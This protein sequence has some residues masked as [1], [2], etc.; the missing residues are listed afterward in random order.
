MLKTYILR[1]F[2]L[3]TVTC[4]IAI[5]VVIYA[6]TAS[7]RPRLNLQNTTVVSLMGLDQVVS[8]NGTVTAAQNVDL[9]FERGG[10]VTSL[11]GDVGTPVGK[12]QVIARVESS[13]LD[14]EL[15]QAQAALSGENIKLQNLQSSATSSNEAGSSI[16]TT[17][18]NSRQSLLVQLSTS[19]SAADGALSTYV[20]NLFSNARTNPSFGVTINQNGSVYDITAPASTLLKID[21][22]RQSLTMLMS[23]WSSLAA[24]ATASGNDQDI[25]AAITASQS[26]LQ[27]ATALLTDISAVFTD[28][29]PIDAASQALY[30]GYKTNILLAETAIN[31]NVSALKSSEEAYAQASASASPYSISLEQVAVTTAQSQ[32]A[33]IE[34]QIE[35]GVL[36]SPIDGVITEENIKLGE[37]AGANTPAVSVMSDGLLQID[38]YVFRS[39]H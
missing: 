6:F 39:R 23:S 19:Y 21:A 33:G 15:V 26:A 3:V 34:A 4:V 1:P 36:R 11:V 25:S 30:A 8:V 35:Q 20:D 38:A 16:Q 13:G 37:V 17:I 32:V 28:Y 31:T 10:T 22:E 5:V 9:S 29:S 2:T 12:G 27:T 7:S 14:A 24:S 18:T